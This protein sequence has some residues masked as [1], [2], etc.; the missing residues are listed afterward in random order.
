[1]KNNPYIWS[2]LKR[3]H[4][5]AINAGNADAPSKTANPRNH[6][7]REIM[8]KLTKTVLSLTLA[9]LPFIT[10][11]GQLHQENNY[12]AITKDT[13]SG[14]YNKSLEDNSGPWYDFGF[15][16]VTTPKDT[17][18]CHTKIYLSRFKTLRGKSYGS[19]HFSVDD[20]TARGSGDTGMRR[21]LFFGTKRIKYYS[22]CI[23][24]KAK[25]Y[26]TFTNPC[27]N[28]PYVKCYIADITYYP[29]EKYKS[30]VKYGIKYKKYRPI[31]KYNVLVPPKDSAKA[32]AKKKER[33]RIENIKY[34]K[35]SDKQIKKIKKK[36]AKQNKRHR[37]KAAIQLKA[38]AKQKAAAFQKSKSDNSVDIDI[39][40]RISGAYNDSIKKAQE[41][42]KYVL[43][44]C[45]CNKCRKCKCTKQDCQF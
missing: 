33:E 36:L 27:T 26:Q 11:T 29:V 19:I 28:K 32:Y 1:M 30:T 43:R 20:L 40:Y 35:W 3:F 38:R 21:G 18:V 14:F 39:N 4:A 13:A 6:K 24:Y 31:E 7:N 16:H 5:N 34:E 15:S 9:F 37:E 42:L 45:E 23:R 2:D 41:E 22:Q 8:N 12:N 17:F 44:P 10:A 25:A